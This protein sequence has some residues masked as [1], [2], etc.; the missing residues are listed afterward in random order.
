LKLQ[1]SRRILA[2]FDHIAR[3]FDNQ[4]DQ[5]ATKLPARGLRASI[6]FGFFAGT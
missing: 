3:E 1:A 2:V 4:V 5:L 6:S